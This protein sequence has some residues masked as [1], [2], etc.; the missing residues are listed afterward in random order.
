MSSII[1]LIGTFLAAH[2]LILVGIIVVTGLIVLGLSRLK[3]KADQVGLVL[4][5]LDKVAFII[6]QFMPDKWEPVYDA[7]LA[8][9][10]DVANGTYTHDEATAEAIK[11]FD[12]GVKAAG[13]TLVPLEVTV[14]HKAIELVVDVIYKDKAAAVQALAV[15]D[16]PAGVKAMARF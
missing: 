14:S 5:V 10:N 3:G 4:K 8:A 13:L 7:L 15:K 1:T 6:K 2:G 16:T 9:V 11:L 12:A